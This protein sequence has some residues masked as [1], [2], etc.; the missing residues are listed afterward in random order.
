MHLGPCAG[1]GETRMVNRSFGSGGN[2]K[3]RPAIDAGDYCADCFEKLDLGW[4]K[5]RART[6]QNVGILDDNPYEQN[7]V[8]DLEEATGYDT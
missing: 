2:G 4:G 6:G 5:R 3:D 7:A 8:R 1:C